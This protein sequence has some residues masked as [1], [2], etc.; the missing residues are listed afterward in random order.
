MKRQLQQA[1]K[2]KLAVWTMV[3]AV[4]ERNGHLRYIRM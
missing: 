2:D 1:R 3:V 4:E